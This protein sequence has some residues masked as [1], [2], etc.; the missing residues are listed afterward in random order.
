[1]K[2]VK[3]MPYHPM[4]EKLTDILCVKT[5]NTNRLFFQ[6]IVAQHFAQVAS[7]MRANIETL[8]RGLIPI[9]LY[10]IALGTSGLG[11]GRSVNMMEEEILHGFREK[12]TEQTFPLAAENHLIKLAIKRSARNQSDYD[13]EL[14]KVKREF[15]ETG[16][17]VFT[18]DSG[19]TAAIK[20]ARHKL[21][22]ANLGSMNLCI[23]ELGSNLLGN[24]E[25]LNTFLET[26]D[27][28]KLKQKLIKNTK[29][30]LRIE[31]IPGRTPSNMLLF[32][33]PSSLLNG[34]KV[35]DEF[36]SMLETGFARRCLFAYVKIHER[37]AALTPRQILDQRLDNTTN[38]FILDT[39]DHITKLADPSYV[40]SRVYIDED[41]TLLL[42]EYEQMC[43]DRACKLGEHVDILKAEITHRYFKVLKLAGTYAF[44]DGSPEITEDHL[45]Y[46][47]KLVEASGTSFEQILK[48]DRPYVKLAK[49]IADIDRPITQVD[50]VE[51][52]PFYRGTNQSKVDMLNLAT[53]YGY[54]NNIIIKTFT[55]DNIDYISGETLEPTDLNKMIVSYSNKL[56]VGYREDFAPFDNLNTLTQ[57]N[58]VHWCNHHFEEGNRNEDSA[59]PGFNMIVLDVDGGIKLSTAKLLLD[60][61]K[62]MFYTT[63][64]HTE[65]EN[66]FR[67]I[68]PT[69]YVLKMDAKDY[70]EFFSNVFDWLPF[71]VDEATSQRARKWLSYKGTFEFQDGVLLDVLPFIP[72]TRKNEKFQQSVLD[73]KGMD[74][75]E[76]W[77]I[78]SAK[79]G[80]QRNNLLHRYA[81]ILVDA[82]L[83]AD[84]IGEHIMKL[85]AKLPEPLSELE[86]LKTVMVTVN[87]QINLKP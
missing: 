45:Y 59:I 49:Y 84:V 80:G 83:T 72:K 64:R 19:T 30:N 39:A 22:M 68:L 35:E 13:E 53:T 73:L 70:K 16:P 14:E 44:I 37:G 47:I 62:A 18:F 23:D 9:N 78:N 79:E 7:M 82:G 71:D 51:D 25:L 26:Y 36:Y 27:L 55:E 50:L 58:G 8:D 69:N 56:A 66:R 46:A 38:Q 86:I 4:A 42:I 67:I 21:L 48:R 20:Q 28:G 76:R 57:K 74:S 31:E 43:I 60:G 77:V 87:K 12:F 75:L 1:M 24:L 54:Q 11:K 33:T 10:S 85:N 17:L 52:L 29:E 3:D 65:D 40:D 15:R 61:Y 63:K 5:Q 81:L 6:V 34:S 41:V 2:P 32:G